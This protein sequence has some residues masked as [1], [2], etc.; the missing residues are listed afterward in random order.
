MTKMNENHKRKIIIILIIAIAFFI[1][2]TILTGVLL[3]RIT[4]KMN[5][6]TN[7][8]FLASSQIIKEGLD[9]KIALDEEMLHTFSDLIA[10]EPETDL[11]DTL[12]DYVNSS[13]FFKLTYLSMDGTGVDSMGDPADMTLLPFED[14]A[15]S[16]GVQGNSAAYHGSSG[17]LEIAYQVPVMKNG[18]QIG[19]LYAQRVLEDFDSPSL[20]M[21]HNGE[22][23]AYVIN[24]RDGEWLIT[25]RG[26]GESDSLY[27]YLENENNTAATLDSLDSAVKN[28]KSG[29]ISILYN[30]EDY[31][32]CFLPLETPK[33]SC[34][35]T[36]IPKAVIQHEAFDIL[37]MLK[38]L[39]LIL[40]VAGV[41]ICLLIVG[42]QSLKARAKEREYREKLFENLS[43]NI[44]FA[45]MLY[46]PASHKTELLSDN[47][48][49]IVGVEAK[50][51][52]KTPELIFQH[53]GVDM[54]EIGDDFLNGR[55]TT[56]YLRECRVGSGPDELARWIAIHLIPADYGQY[57]AVF[58]DT[59]NE[60]HM[61]ETLTDALNQARNTNQARTLFFSSI[62]HDI[63]TPMNGIVGMTNIAMSHLDNPKKVELCL[64]KI[65]NASDHLLGL[66]NEIL[67]MSRIESGKFNLKEDKFHLPTLLSDILSF[68]KPEMQRKNH[69]LIMKSSVLEH[70][71]F[72]GDALNL[73]KIF[74][75]LLSNAVKYTP[76]G[77]RILLCIEESAHSREI[78]NI[79]FIVEDTGIGMNEDFIKRIF[80][81]FERAE[82]SRMSK[83]TGTGLGMS[84]TKG[85]I[86]SMGGRIQ[87]ESQLDKGS[88]F[89]VDLPLRLPTDQ[90]FETYVF[91]SRPVL[92]ASTD[93][94]ACES[95]RLILEG[96]GLS[97]SWVSSGPEAVASVQRAHQNQEDYFIII[98]ENK[99]VPISGIETARKIRALEYG[100]AP[101][102]LL[103]AYDREEIIEDAGTAGVDGFLAKPYFKTELL[104]TLKSYMQTDDPA[105]VQAECPVSGSGSRLQGMRFLTAEDNDL[106]R[107][108]IYE[109]LT[110]QGGSVDTA[111][112]GKEALEL[113]EKSSAGYYQM[114]FLDIHMPV[115]D[116]LDAAR[117]IRRSHHPDAFSIPIVAMTADVF[118][119]DIH[120]SRDAGMD[121]HL[122]KPI[123]LDE[124]FRIIDQFRNGREGTEEES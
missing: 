47:I 41:F 28:G 3:T 24:A 38:V 105:D 7:Q 40:L 67:D 16:R 57:L 83:I 111:V 25:G 62:S 80:K 30:Q 5:N 119:E 1:L 104:K 64:K 56:Q 33:G 73:Q 51:A 14:I 10:S 122:S 89:T 37:K 103:S 110:A 60:H 22:G 50:Q 82:D 63:R 9:N 120:K 2:A 93:P 44:D 52:M 118:N 4:T 107:E 58:H 102:I 42:R 117:A 84:I 106:N 8:S 81:P 46:T 92:I 74:L 12:Q 96:T 113:F 90:T 66:I 35:I 95:I 79:R 99:L 69:E 100:D 36:M 43:S 49:E 13:G 123:I 86:D 26:A 45:F 109:L 97:V 94:E 101:V 75:N 114:I 108:I 76:D 124:L 88:R 48:S 115:M 55:L 98:L 85:I 17:W 20:F 54:V 21:F 23:Q 72:L 34:L 59:T 116:G 31:L 91:D 71:T 32:L 121:A 87:V 15:L 61:R 29:T 18:T 19:A 27:E 39:L 112:N 6:S 77:G 53:L 65:L 70:D 11:A 68:I 78:A